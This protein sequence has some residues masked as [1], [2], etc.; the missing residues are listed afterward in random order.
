[1]TRDE[2]MVDLTDEL[3]DF[4]VRCGVAPLRRTTR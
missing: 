1:L 4:A 2:V 3:E